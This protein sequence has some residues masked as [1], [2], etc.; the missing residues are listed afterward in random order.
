MISVDDCVILTGVDLVYYAGNSQESL[1]NTARVTATHRETQTPHDLKT[2][3]KEQKLTDWSEKMLC[4][5]FTKILAANR[6]IETRL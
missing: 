5:R 3:K 6:S 4:S 1:L 2:R